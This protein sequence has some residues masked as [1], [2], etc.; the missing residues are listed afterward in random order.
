V[1][2]TPGR[3]T[4]LSQRGE[5]D[6]PISGPADAEVARGERIAQLVR[7]RYCGRRSRRSGSGRDGAARASLDGTVA[8]PAPSSTVMPA[9]LCSEIGGEG[10]RKLLA[11]KIAIVGAGGTA[12]RRSII[13]RRPDRHV[14]VIDDTSSAS[15]PAPDP[16]R[17]PASAGED[18]SG[19]RGGCTAQRTSALRVNAR[20]ASTSSR[21]A[22][23]RGPVLDGCDNFAP[24]G[25]VRP[26]H[27]RTRSGVGGDRPFRPDRLPRLGRASPA[28]AASATP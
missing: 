26:L 23:G 21:P 11:A 27:R 22:D 2:N 12:R 5:G 25:R 1:L 20:L 4:A 28:T 13:W 10:R 9:I 8:S 18:G 3:S 24:P 6:S 14:A 15:F 7:H 17:H 19:G 16:V